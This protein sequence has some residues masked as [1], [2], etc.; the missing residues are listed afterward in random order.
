MPAMCV[1]GEPDSWGRSE[2]MIGAMCARDSMASARCGY[3][4]QDHPQRRPGPEDGGG[5]HPVRQ[6]ECD[7]VTLANP[8]RPQ[9]AG[10]PAGCVGGFGGVAD[11]PGLGPN[12]RPDRERLT[13]R[14]G[15]T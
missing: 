14:S 12:R 7:D 1:T 11:G 13:R 3:R 15:D 5:F 6:L 10:E 4:Q 2:A 9:A 8:S